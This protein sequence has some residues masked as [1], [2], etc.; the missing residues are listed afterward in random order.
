MEEEEDGDEGEDEEVGNR[1]NAEFTQ[2]KSQA[3]RVERKKSNKEREEENG[4]EEGERGEE[5]DE[6]GALLSIDDREGSFVKEE[7]REEK[8]GV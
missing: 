5:V 6:F 2:R 8:G 7:S 4:D 3:M 1:L